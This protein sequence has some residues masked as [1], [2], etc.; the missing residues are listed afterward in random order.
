MVT[1]VLIIAIFLTA[2]LICCQSER[3][4]YGKWVIEVVQMK[5]NASKTEM[6]GLALK[7]FSHYEFT[8]NNDLLLYN[9]YDEI[10]QKEKFLLSEF[11]NELLIKGSADLVLKIDIIS[12]T[13]IKLEDNNCL[14]KLRRK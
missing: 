11:G 9:I 8:N 6:H 12:E 10:L 4:L 14:I 7:D 3:E 1:K 5:E 2:L 13:E